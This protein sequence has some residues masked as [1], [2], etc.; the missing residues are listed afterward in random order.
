MYK[1]KQNDGKRWTVQGDEA[2]G[3]IV[4]RDVD[5]PDYTAET[6]IRIDDNGTLHIETCHGFEY[7]VTNKEGD[8]A[9]VE[10]A[11]PV[12]ALLMQ[13][14]LPRMTYVHGTLVGKTDTMG[15]FVPIGEFMEQREQRHEETGSVNPRDKKGWRINM[16]FNNEL[17]PWLPSFEGPGSKKKA[18]RV[19]GK[20]HR[21]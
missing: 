6:V 15:D 11:G 4:L 7:T 1:M 12:N 13:S 2:D 5:D 20:F 21:R 9:V 14:L 3:R 17:A 19:S 16:R 10:F 8:G 18:H